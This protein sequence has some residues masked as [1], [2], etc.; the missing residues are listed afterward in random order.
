MGKLKTFYI[1]LENSKGVFL[2]GQTINGKL[3]IE[4]NAEM[5][6]REIRCTFKG[7]AYVHWSESET[8]GTGSNRRTETI[9]YT[10]SENY[11]NQTVPVFGR[12]MG[13]GDKNCLPPGQHVYPFSFQL[14]P[15]LPSSFEGGIGYVRYTIKGTIDKPWKF[16]HTTKRPFTVIASLDLNSQPT[17]ARSEQNQN[18]KYLCC[19]CCK[20]GPITGMLKLDRLGYVPGEA[21]AF[22]AEVQNMTNRVCGIHAKLY[23]TTLFRTLKKSKTTT[24]EVAKVVYQDVQPGETEIWSGGRLVIPPLPPSFLEGCRIIDL[25]YY[26]ELI[27]DP[28]GPAIDLHV[29]LLVIIGTIP[30][31]TVVQQYQTQYGVPATEQPTLPPSDTATSDPPMVG[32]APM[33]LPPPTY[34]EC[35]FGKT[36]IREEGDS[37]YTRGEMNFAP[38]YVYYHDLSKQPQF[39]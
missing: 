20:S 35:V 39:N 8:T 5:K 7:L 6:M 31:Q 37:E 15:N 24:S 10:A 16:D 1:E 9:D 22:N 17:A 36:N 29:P 14:P 26:F 38:A 13:M 3:V 30:L 4:L 28:S 25:N 34:S 2:A 18:S 11:F 19:L 32:A 12:G 27:V 21:I 33:S 23:M